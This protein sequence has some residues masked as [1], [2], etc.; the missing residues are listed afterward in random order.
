MLK[1]IDLLFYIATYTILVTLGAICAGCS[2]DAPV[3][4]Q[5]A[6]ALPTVDILVQYWGTDDENVDPQKES[7]HAN[8]LDCDGRLIY[9]LFNWEDYDTLRVPECSLK[10]EFV[11]NWALRSLTFWPE[12]GKRYL[13]RHPSIEVR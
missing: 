11:D 6:Y 12:A 1:A 3:A 9:V 8:L 4:E 2:T 13:V 7:D 10:V 5:S